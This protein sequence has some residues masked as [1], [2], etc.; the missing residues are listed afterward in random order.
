MIFFAHIHSNT[1]YYFI[2][3]FKL[4]L[5]ITFLMVS[6]TIFAQSNQIEGTVKSEN[7]QIINGGNLYPAPLIVS[8]PQFQTGPTFHPDTD[9]LSNFIQES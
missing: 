9:S 6:T 7:N 5:S 4:S 8:G 2:K 1:M 3:C